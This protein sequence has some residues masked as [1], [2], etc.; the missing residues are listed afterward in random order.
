MDPVDRQAA[1]PTDAVNVVL[2]FEDQD[3]REWLAAAAMTP[4]RLSGSGEEC[5][6]RQMPDCVFRLKGFSVVRDV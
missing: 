3:G 5:A 4:L 2:T 6:V 1:A